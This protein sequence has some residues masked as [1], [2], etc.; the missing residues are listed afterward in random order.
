MP[1]GRLHRQ[2]EDWHGRGASEFMTKDGKY[3]LNFKEKD[4]DGSQILSP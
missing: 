4:N 3:D 1:G 2:G